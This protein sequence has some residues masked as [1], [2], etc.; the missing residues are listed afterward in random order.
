MERALSYSRAEKTHLF[1]FSKGGSLPSL[2]MP[3]A[4]A[5]HGGPGPV[6][7]TPQVTLTGSFPE[8]PG[9]SKGAEQEKNT[10]KESGFILPEN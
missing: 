1:V 9:V 5:S 2:R 4:A 10:G 6:S 7:P 3:S 8:P